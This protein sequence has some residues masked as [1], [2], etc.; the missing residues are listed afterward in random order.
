MNFRLL[1]RGDIIKFLE[2]PESDFERCGFNVRHPR[3]IDVKKRMR[4]K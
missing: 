3:E 2:A 4:M 1:L